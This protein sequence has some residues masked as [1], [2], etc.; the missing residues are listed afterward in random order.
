MQFRF[1]VLGDKAIDWEVSAP[2]AASDSDVLGELGYEPSQYV[3]KS[4]ASR[5]ENVDGPYLCEGALVEL[6]NKESTRQYRRKLLSGPSSCL[7]LITESGSEAG[8]VVKFPSG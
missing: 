7:T 2:R 5:R 6:V 1:T 3:I 8:R 4:A